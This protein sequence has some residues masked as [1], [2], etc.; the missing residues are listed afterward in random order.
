[1]ADHRPRRPPRPHRPAEPGITPGAVRRQARPTRPTLSP[2]HPPAPSLPPPLDKKSPPAQGRPRHDM[3][4]VRKRC[5]VGLRFRL[6]PERR[7]GASSEFISIYESCVEQ[8]LLRPYTQGD[9]RRSEVSHAACRIQDREAV[10]TWRALWPPPSSV[11][12]DATRISPST[13]RSTPAAWHPR[14]SKPIR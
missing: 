11:R 12:P 10:K 6:L 1:M 13:I 4:P 14:S 2:R 9:F 3:A 5:I 8:A 7:H